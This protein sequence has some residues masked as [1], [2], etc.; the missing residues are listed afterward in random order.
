MEK[1][2]KVSEERFQAPGGKLVLWTTG[3]T[4]YAN[5]QPKWRVVHH[6]AKGKGFQCSEWMPKAEAFAMAAQL[7][8][9][10]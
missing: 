9:E 7:G 10:A 4:Q 5:E 3:Q 1:L 8:W 2:V 6:L